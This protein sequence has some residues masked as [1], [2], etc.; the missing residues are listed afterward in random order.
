MTQ[1]PMSDGRESLVDSKIDALLAKMSALGN[2]VNQVA[3][4][5]A[6]ADAAAV[7][8]AFRAKQAKEEAQSG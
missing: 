8:R 4:V 2:Q 1:E 7:R 5:L 3:E 6:R